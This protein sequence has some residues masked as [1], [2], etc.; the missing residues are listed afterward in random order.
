MAN[1]GG[2]SWKTGI[3]LAG[4]LIALFVTGCAV[5]EVARLNNRDLTELEVDGS[6]LYMAHE[7]NSR[8]LDQFLAV[9]AEHPEI[10]TLVLTIV[11]GSVDDEVNLALGRKVRQLGLDTHLVGGGMIASG[12]VDLFLAGVERKIEKG[13]FVGVHSW[14]SGV[15]MKGDQLDRDHPDHRLYLDYYRDLGTPE[16]FYWFTLE[17][18][19][20]R[21]M[22]WMTAAEL[23]RFQVVT[24]PVVEPGG[25]PTPFDAAIDELG[26]ELEGDSDRPTPVE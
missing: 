11:P 12:G 6:R 25:E 1:W 23:E 17:A 26:R 4:G 19:P 24:Q 20:S 13:A 3:G 7:V 8:T 14:A 2:R 9:V 21:G 22:H 15:A 18:A 16:D 10:D 5:L